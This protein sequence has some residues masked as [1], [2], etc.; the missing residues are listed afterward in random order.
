[1]PAILHLY[2]VSRNNVPSLTDY[3][4][5]THS[6]IFF[7][8]LAHRQ[9]FLLCNNNEITADALQIYSTVSVSVKKCMWLHFS[10]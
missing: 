2:T 10:R 9:N 8:I 4:F 3:S 6:H 1:M 7:I 5:N